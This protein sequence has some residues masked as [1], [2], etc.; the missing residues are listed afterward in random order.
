MAVGV[1]G[2]FRFPLENLAAAR[3][4]MARVI[5]STRAEAGCIQYNYGEDVLDPGL[6]RVSELWESR[7]HLTAHFAT[8]HMAQWQAERPAL[9]LSER[10]VTVYELGA[11]EAV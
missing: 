8:S 9:G 6:F 2:C 4:A 5:T 7:E 10:Q 3:E 1:I 11:A